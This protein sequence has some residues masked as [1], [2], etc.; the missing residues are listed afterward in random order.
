MKRSNPLEIYNMKSIFNP[1]GL[2][3][4]FTTVVVGTIVSKPAYEL[5]ECIYN[6]YSAIYSG[7]KESVLAKKNEKD[8]ANQGHYRQ[9]A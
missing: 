8:V 7:V 5:G 4:T 2:L 3:T 9:A 6:V 1:V